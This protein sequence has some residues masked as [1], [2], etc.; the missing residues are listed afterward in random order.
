MRTEDRREFESH[1]DE[2]A[3]LNKGETFVIMYPTQNRCI[4]VM[5]HVL[6]VL[7]QRE[8]DGI[9]FFDKLRIIGSNGGVLQ[10]GSTPNEE[11]MIRG[12]SDIV[13]GWGLSPSAMLWLREA[14]VI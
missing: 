7:A 13:G 14:A 2:L 5:R 1:A 10:F 9:A 11:M 4:A 6:G 3:R 12:R 8:V